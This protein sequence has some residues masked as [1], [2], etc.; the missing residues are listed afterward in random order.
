MKGTACCL[1]SIAIVTSAGAEPRPAGVDPTDRLLQ[2]GCLDVTKAPYL[3]DAGGIKDSTQAIQL[4]VNEARDH[5]LVCFFPE[6]T[7]LISDTISCEQQVSKLDTPRHVDNGTQHYWPVQRPIVL[8]GSTKGKR[9]VLKLARDAKGFDDLSKPKIAVWIWAQTWFDAPGKEEPQ[10]GKEQ[11]NISFNHVFKGIDIDIRGHAGAIGIRHSGSQGSTLQDATIRAEDAYAGMNCCCGQ[12][13]GTYNIEVIGGQYGIVI[14]PDSRF[15]LLT[16]CVF[17]GQTGAAIRYAKGGSQVPTLLVG[18]LLEPVGDAVVNF[19][20]ERSYAGISMV[21]C[22]V[23]MKRGGV[24]CKTRKN[25]NIFLEDT[26]VR[27]A[28]SVCSG[29]S[30]IPSSNA[31]THIARC[32]SHSDQGV[33]LINGVQSSGEIIEWKTLSSE[34]ASQAIRDRHYSKSPSFEDEDAVSVTSFGAKGDGTTDDTKA[35]EKAIASHSKVFVPKGDYRLSGT[36]HLGAKTHL[37][38][39]SRALS[40]IGG[41]GSERGRSPGGREADSF[42]VATADDPDAAP[43]LSFL[44]VRGGVQWRSGQGIGMLASGSLAISGHGGGRIYGLMAM[45]RPLLL[46]GIRQPT[47]FY[48]LNVERIVTNPQS[49][50]QDCS[51]VRV[52]YFKVE[53]GTIQRE[54]AGDENT[55]CRI[56]RSRD[57]RVYCMYGNVRKLAGRPM[58][59]IVNSDEVVISQLK[60][61]SPGDFPHLTETSGGVTSEIPSTK[62]CALF[63]RDSKGGSSR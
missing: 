55:P 30:P 44:S 24:I 4:A 35:F 14:E 37:F 2:L 11:A 38:G 7:Y 59:D 49:K 16:A 31:W 54:N 10:W 57:V 41:T 61:F 3:A 18:C 53:S 40:S 33:N 28:N 9:P 12:G 8:I 50:I 27:G 19:T 22:V 51:H 32:S 21:D 39:L 13:G 52:Y 47:S 26:Y 17:K 6:G 56:T 34:P 46:T 20:T 42:V 23:D 1:L 25:E 62:T 5:G 60:A 58:L 48:A 15:P 45:G 29:G 43:G 36:L 63:V